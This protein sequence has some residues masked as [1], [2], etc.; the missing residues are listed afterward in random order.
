MKSVYYNGKKYTRNPDS[1]KRDE[2]VYFKRIVGGTSEY[3]H[4]VKWADAHG[5]IPKNYH[6]HHI[7]GNPLNNELSNLECLSAKDHKD[8]HPFTDEQKAKMR[9]NLDRIRPMTKEWHS[10]EE[11]RKWHSEHAKRTVAAP[12]EKEMICQECGIVFISNASHNRKGFC[13]NAHKAAFRRKSGVDDIDH[14]CQFCKCT[15]IA[16]KYA[17]RETCSKSCA[18]RLR[19]ARKTK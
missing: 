12:Q 18:N 3:L 5:P 13:S 6:I 1:E 17:K 11:G 7:D 15:F 9:D 16:N 10:S 14:T 2:R 19:H 8:K 4:R